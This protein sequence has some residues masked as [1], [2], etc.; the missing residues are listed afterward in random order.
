MKQHKYAIIAVV[1][2]TIVTIGLVVYNQGQ[3][4]PNEIALPG[5]ESAVGIDSN[6]MTS[7]LI[8]VGGLILIGIILTSIY[9][10]R[11]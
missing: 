10:K 2:I 7:K 6:L 4:S 1:L 5:Y 8:I 3:L 11:T 9:S